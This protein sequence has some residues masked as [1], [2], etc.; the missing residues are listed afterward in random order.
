[1]PGHPTNR[2]DFSYPNGRPHRDVIAGT[3]IY[4]SWRCVPMTDVAIARVEW[5]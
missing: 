4:I 5:G 3:A 1:M 2:N